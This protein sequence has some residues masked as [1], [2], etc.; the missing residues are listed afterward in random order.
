MDKLHSKSATTSRA[1][2]HVSATQQHKQRSLLASTINN[3]GLMQ[4]V[5][6]KASDLTA[7]THLHKVDDD[8]PL[9]HGT[10][11]EK[12]S[13]WKS[14]KRWEKPVPNA[15][16]WF[17]EK[18]TAFSLH[19]A[20]RYVPEDNG[21]I[22]VHKYSSK[23]PLK[24]LRFSDCDDL[25]DFVDKLDNKGYID[26]NNAAAAARLKKLAPKYDGYFL[27][28]DL[29]REEKEIILFGKGLKKLKREKVRQWDFVKRSGEAR[30]RRSFDGLNTKDL[31]T[32]EGRLI[33]K[34]LDGTKQY[35]HL[36]GDGPGY[37]VKGNRNSDFK[38]T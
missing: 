14:W 3:G 16:A 37:L 2:A 35:T 15:P 23:K 31:Y 21:S 10:S 27:D 5:R 33:T 1:Q 11:V 22:Y 38:I 36:K 13:R 30:A 7:R 9:T 34:N 25:S 19:A 6:A 32:Y 18:N 28:Q 20:T 29:V 26:E 8:V 24:L 4:R 17:G 12:F